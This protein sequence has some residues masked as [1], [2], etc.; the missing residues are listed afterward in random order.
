GTLTGLAYDRNFPGATQTT[1][2][3]Y[4]FI[5]DKL[6]TVGSVNGTPNS[7]NGGVV[8]VVGSSGVVVQANT[9]GNLGFDIGADGAGYLNLVVGGKSN[10]YTQDLASGTVTLVGDFGATTMM[11]ISVAPAVGFALNS[12]GS[13]HVAG[14]SS[15]F[16][17]TAVDVYGNGVPGYK[18]TVTFSSSD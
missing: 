12:L 7:P 11:D 16:T 13:T 3:G 4:D 6:V 2:Y 18:G 5:G 9:Q 8:T 10:L 14:A 17:V 1:L 15:P